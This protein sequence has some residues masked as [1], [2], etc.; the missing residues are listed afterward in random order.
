MQRLLLLV[1]THRCNLLPRI[2]GRSKWW[3]RDDSKSSVLVSSILTVRANFNFNN[4]RVAQRQSSSFT[5]RRS[6]FRYPPCVPFFKS[7]G[8]VAV[9]QRSHKPCTWV[10]IPPPQPI[11]ICTRTF[12]G[13]WFDCQSSGCRIG[14]CRVRHFNRDVAQLVRALACQARGRGFKPRRFCHFNIDMNAPRLG[15]PVVTRLN[16][17]RS[18]ACLPSLM[19]Q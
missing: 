10:R 5:R 1:K 4:A 11:S 12:N 7:R 18:Q 6:G 15:G 19:P 8:R 9:T 16:L 2:Y 3:L 14:T 17:V 13:R